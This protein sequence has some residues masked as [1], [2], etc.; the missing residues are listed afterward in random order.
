MRL[1]PWRPARVLDDRQH[2]G[3]DGMY[4]VEPVCLNVKGH[5]RPSRGVR[6]LGL[7]IET[8]AWCT[9]RALNGKTGLHVFLTGTLL[10][11]HLQERQYFVGV[12]EW[13]PV[14]IA[15]LS[16]EQVG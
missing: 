13:H 10:Q 2:S 5:A 7:H 3:R 4:A 12:T 11:G 16:I 9:E 14:Q 6:V 8:G 1:T 15:K